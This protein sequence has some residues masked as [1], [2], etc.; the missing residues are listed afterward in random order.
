MFLSCDR[1]KCTVGFDTFHCAGCSGSFSIRT[2]CRVCAALLS[3]NL[4]KISL[5]L[6]PG[7]LLKEVPKQSVFI[8]LL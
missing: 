3:F 5:H 7:T 1:C 2:E 8:F 4:L 6:H